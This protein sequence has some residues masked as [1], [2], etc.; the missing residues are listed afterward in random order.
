MNVAQDRIVVSPTP[1]GL[2]RSFGDAFGSLPAELLDQACKRVGI[3]GMVFAGI[4]LFVLLMQNVAIGFLD[5]PVPDA[6]SRVWPM[7]GNLVAGIG[8]ALSL[9]L[10]FAAR[11]LHT[12]P[13]ILLDV[14]LGYEVAGAALVAFLNSWSAGALSYSLGGVSWVCVI[15]LVY[16]AIAPATPRKV[17][18]AGLLAASMDPVFFLLGS[19]SGHAS[20]TIFTQLW[21]FV[22]NYICV[23]LSMI[24]LTVIRSLSRRVSRERELGAYKIG[25]LIGQGGM[26]EV[27]RATHRLLA[28]PAAIKLIRPE[29]VAGGTQESGEVVVERF[30]REARAAAALRSPHTIELYDFGTTDEGNLYYVMELLEGLN[31]QDLVER[32]G[33]VDPSRAVHFLRQTSLSLAEAH[34]Q[35]L[36]HRDIKP[37]NIVAARMGVTVDY[38]KVLDFGLV[39]V[40][41]NAAEPESLLLTSPNVTTGTPAFMA[42]EVA[43]GKDEVTSAADIYSLGCVAFW[44]LT[45]TYVFDAPNSI[46]MLVQHV[47]TEPS[48]PSDRSELSIPKALDAIILS[49]LAKEPSE[50]PAS[51]MDLYRRLKEI[52]LEQQWTRDRAWAWWKLHL[53]EM[54]ATVQSVPRTSE[55]IDVPVVRRG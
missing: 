13:A 22:P 12:R 31:L 35:G 49:C 43:L 37:S 26:G 30:R 16:P 51:A 3:A 1:A 10:V 2:S 39:K 8:L 34:E 32:Y 5:A 6:V 29:A 19:L 46:D 50:R 24:P 54:T 33:P 36:V 21:A 41:Q 48:P 53:P 4:W 18:I 14:G 28:R 52:P 20:A 47:K 42:P 17:L 55:G 27:R 7:P 40:T 38:V 15:I 45:G 23:V 9:A 11:Q 44:L 25:G